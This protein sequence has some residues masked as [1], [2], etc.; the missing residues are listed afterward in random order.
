MEL[1]PRKRTILL[2]VSILFLGY[3]VIFKSFYLQKDYW[4]NLLFNKTEEIIGY[5]INY[6][7]DQISLFPYP[8]V[9]LENLNINNKTEN[10]SLSIHSNRTTVYFSWANILLNKWKIDKFEFEDSKIEISITSN[11]DSHDTST[12]NLPEKIK[13][14]QINRISLKNV[15]IKFIIN[16]K[17]D[18]VLLNS[19]VF[20]HSSLIKN[21]IEFNIDYLGGNTVADFNVGIDNSY[22]SIDDI[23]FSGTAYIKNFPIKIFQPFYKILAN[24]NFYNSNA[25][26]ELI[27][28]KGVNSE[29]EDRK[30]VV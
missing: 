19:F 13:N 9:L 6:A 8:V 30:S 15:F 1:I 27:F 17:E 3:I 23:Q 25:T 29:I 7:R 28:N 4:K 12:L 5:K 21:K 16:S 26:G 14:L 20:N 2:F 18:T 10:F 24:S 11:K 22:K